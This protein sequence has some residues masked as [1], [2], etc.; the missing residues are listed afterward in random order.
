MENMALLDQNQNLQNF[1][2]DFLVVTEKSSKIKTLGLFETQYTK[3]T[4]KYALR[5]PLYF[6]KWLMELFCELICFTG[7]CL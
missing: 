4:C 5:A 3:C 6:I 7:N 2:K 1:G